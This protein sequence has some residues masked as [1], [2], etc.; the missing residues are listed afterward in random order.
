MC[1]K[2]GGVGIVHIGLTTSPVK[3]SSI[4]EKQQNPL[5]FIDLNNFAAYPT[6]AVGYLIRSLRLNNYR[7][8]LLSPLALGI[9]AFSRDDRETWK[10]QLLRRI[11][12]SSHPV[13]RYLH[14]YLRNAYSNRLSRPHPLMIKEVHQ[15]IAK[16]PPAI[17]ISAYLT[18]YAMCVE[19]GRI[20]KSVGIPVLLGGP[21]FN[22][23]KVTKEWLSIEGVTAIVGA[24]VDFT[25]SDIV[26]TLLHN[27]DL[28]QH[29]G[30]FLLDNSLLHNLHGR[31][32]EPLK[33]LDQLPV[34]DFT[35]FPWHKYP[36]PIIP[37]MTGRGCSWGAC[38]FCG[39]VISA[40]GRTFR[41]RGIQPVL[42][43]LKQ[44]SK[45]HR[46]KDFI[47][48]DIKLNSD[49]QVWNGL[50][51]HFQDYVPDGRWIGTVH[52]NHQGDNGLSSER[53]IAAKKAGLT[54][55]SFGLES[56]SQRLLDEMKKGTRIEECSDF[57][58]AAYNAGISVRTSMM[59]GFPGETADDL[60]QTTLFLKQHFYALDRVRLSLFKPLPDT[61]FDR[62]YQRNPEKYSNLKQFKWDYKLARGL[63]RYHPSRKKAYRQAKRELLKI[64]Y[65]IN[66]KALNDDAKQFNGM[67]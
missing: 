20:A 7:V 34:P 28:S 13:L 50:I 44:Q 9:P 14:D 1:K 2:Q 59:L 4:S 3:A 15:A 37:I 49:L 33:Q 32:A 51:N 29:A 53:L 58:L 23:K 31:M 22:L 61:P 43:E 35:D 8:D 12:F 65:E 16:N 63:Y 10:D 45:T 54:R 46:S 56:A 42:N 27:G 67:M 62:M 18:Q 21:F 60:E 39:D 38:T 11:Y 40:N 30:V 6:L 52:V 36:Y 64:V 55:I 19:I 47:F 25:L 5:L 57:I 41:S 66:R 24:E 17:L 26:T 48:L